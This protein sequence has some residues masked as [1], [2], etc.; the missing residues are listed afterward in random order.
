MAGICDERRQ[1]GKESEIID[2]EYGMSG[3]ADCTVLELCTGEVVPI[4]LESSR[5]VCLLSLMGRKSDPKFVKIALSE[6]NSRHEWIWANRLS[7]S[8]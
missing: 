7:H 3:H 8:V 6:T 5:Q 2:D 1:E 4:W